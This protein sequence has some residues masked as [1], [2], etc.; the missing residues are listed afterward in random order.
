M[1]GRRPRLG[2][3]DHLKSSFSELSP[4]LAKAAT[5]SIIPAESAVSCPLKE[6]IVEMATA[7]EAEG[8]LRCRRCLGSDCH[9][10]FMVCVPCDRCQRYCSQSC[11][12]GARQRQRRAANQRYQKT[13]Q[14]R[15][16]HRHRQRAYRER[17]TG[18]R[19]TDQACQTITPSPS[20]GVTHRPACAICGCHSPWIDPFALPLVSLPSR[21]VR[22]KVG[23]RP[24]NYVFR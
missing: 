20:T 3:I 11:R 4:V 16:T 12:A 14:G 21:R 8:P 19:V 7:S 18:V 23:G 6:G 22:R 9:V 13:E 5:S 2:V 17:R 1:L 15:K 10:I 24:K